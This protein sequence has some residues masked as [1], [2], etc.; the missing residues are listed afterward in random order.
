[1]AEKIENIE[2]IENTNPHEREMADESMVRNLAAQAEAIWPQE[3]PLYARYGLGA[4]PEV[5]DAGCGTGEVSVRLAQLYPAARVLGVDILVPH[6]ERGR[7]RASAMGLGDRVRFEERSVY[8]LELPAGAF[9][10]VVCRH[11]LQ[12]IPHPERVL[13]ELVRVVRPGGWLHVLSEDYG[14]IHFEPRSLDADGFWTT[15]PKPFGEATGTD[16]L[17]GRRTYRL[18]RRLGLRNVTVD[19]LVVDTLRVPRATF[20]AIWEAW[21]DGYAELTSENT[22]ITRSEFIAYFDDMLAT[23]RDPDGYGVWFVP[24][25]AGQVPPA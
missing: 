18:L 25:I 10:L 6:L 1:M 15:A 14:M 22:P 7:A 9:D 20:A 4:A 24:L 5:L 21:R 8:E 12:A 16:L 17:L 23:I 13:A 3:A 2:N 19:Y 11:V